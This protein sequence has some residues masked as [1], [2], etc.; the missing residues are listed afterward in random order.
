MTGTSGWTGETAGSTAGA[1]PARRA[2]GSGTL[3][4]VGSV[5]L[6]I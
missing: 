2:L 6:P 5:D 4:R 3:Y 1:F